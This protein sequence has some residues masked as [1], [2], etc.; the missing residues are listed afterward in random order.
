MNVA[1]ERRKKGLR[2]AKSKGA[3]AAHEQHAEVLTRDEAMF[4]ERLAGKSIR[5]IAAEFGCDPI[6]AQDTI[7]RMCQSVTTQMKLHAVELELERLDELTAAFHEK[8]KAGDVQCAAIVLRV[9]E[10]RAA[11]LGIDSPLR[12]DAVQARAEAEPTQ[13]SFNKIHE[14]ILRVARGGS[15]ALPGNGE[16]PSE[17]NDSP[18]A[19]S[20]V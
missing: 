6:M 12:I 10:R 18:P 14:A 9:S 7:A 19:G 8:A 2:N 16:E 5:S 3:A 11:L 20:E 4:R 15:A 1:L 13:S 17:G